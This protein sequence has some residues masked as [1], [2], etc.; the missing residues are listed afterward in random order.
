MY[1]FFGIKAGL[2]V[3]EILKNDKTKKTYKK[4]NAT[5]ADSGWYGCSDDEGNAKHIFIWVKCEIFI[6]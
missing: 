6:L 1:L 2:S 5:Y 3:S 4:L